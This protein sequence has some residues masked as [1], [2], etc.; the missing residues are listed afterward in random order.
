VVGL[1][2]IPFIVRPLDVLAEVLLD[3]TLRPILFTAIDQNHDGQISLDELYAKLQSRGAVGM[4]ADKVAELFKQ[5]DTDGDGFISME[6][7][8][9]SSVPLRSSFIIVEFVG[10]F[11]RPGIQQPA[12]EPAHLFVF[13]RHV[14]PAGRTVGT[15]CTETSHAAPGAILPRWPSG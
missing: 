6:E 7:W 5:M 1:A 10:E 4:G 15:S 13:G 14:A 11:A 2:V 12:V 9:V 8:C 3:K